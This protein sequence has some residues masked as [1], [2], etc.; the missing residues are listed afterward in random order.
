MENLRGKDLRGAF[1]LAY[2]VDIRPHAKLLSAGF[3][4]EYFAGQGNADDAYWKAS[5]RRR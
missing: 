1:P 4:R 5:A 2:V 3:A